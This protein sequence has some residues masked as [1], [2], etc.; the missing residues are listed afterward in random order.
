MGR[1]VGFAVVFAYFTR[2]E[3]L[4]EESSIYITEMT[5]IK[6]ALKEIH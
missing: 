2:K 4:P 1:K 6:I 5:S 3:A